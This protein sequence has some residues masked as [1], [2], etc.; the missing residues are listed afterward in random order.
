MDRFR[1]LKV[2]L[3]VILSFV[4]LKLILETA[5]SEWAHHHE[6]IVILVS[7]S[8]IVLSLAVSIIASSVIKPPKK[9]ELESPSV[10][11]ER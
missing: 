4:G 7:L 1:Y 8:V 6:T 9:E 5:F 2:G 3:G 11:V 10:P